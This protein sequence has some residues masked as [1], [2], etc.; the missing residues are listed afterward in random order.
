MKKKKKVTG[1]QKEDELWSVAGLLSRSEANRKKRRRFFKNR[2][3]RVEKMHIRLYQEE[4][5]KNIRAA[6]RIQSEKELTIGTQ[7]RRKMKISGK[8]RRRLICEHFP[9]L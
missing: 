7:N 9:Q 6:K 5:K 4:G 8:E 3:A 1:S 2:T